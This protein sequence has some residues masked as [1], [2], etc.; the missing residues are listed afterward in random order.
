MVTQYSLELGR[1]AYIIA[2][3]MCDIKAGESVLIT[4][5]SAADFKPV[6]AIAR[7]AEALGAKVMVAWHSTPKGYGSAAESRMSTSL[8]AAIPASD[9]WIEFNNQ[10][11][12]YSKPWVEALSNNRTRYIVFGSL[13]REQITRCIANIDIETQREFQRE[14]TSLVGSATKMRITAPAGTDIYFEIDPN[15]PI[16]NEMCEASTPGA[17]FLIGQIGW[18]PIEHTINGKIVFDGSFSGGGD[19]ELGILKHPI[20][21]T[22]E[23]GKIVKVD[24]KDEARFVERW[25]ASFDTP[26]MY[27]L[28]HISCGFNP[29]AKLC[30]M[31]T[32]DERVWGATEWGI[33]YQGPFFKG[34]HGDAPTHADGICLNSTIWID[35][36]KITEDGKVVHP[37]LVPIAKKLGK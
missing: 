23:K 29:G 15:R 14:F 31:C 10:W 19:A 24:G 27:N 4:L 25:L 30:G 32:E 11:L 22:I 18:A 36:E 12:L 20:E 5:D 35:D 28:A 13:S 34:N 1:A 17:Y 9:V 7:A 37:R 2:K 21:L 8:K 6:E 3:D 26:Q 33:G 16:A